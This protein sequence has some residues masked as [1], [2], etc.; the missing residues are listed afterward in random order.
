MMQD[1]HKYALALTLIPEIGLRRAK[2]LMDAFGSAQQVFCAKETELKDVKGLAVNVQKSLLAG[3]QAA[4]KRAEEEARFIDEKGIEVFY[5]RDTDYPYRLKDCVDAP[6]LLFGKGHMQVNPGKVLSIVGTRMPSDR[7]KELCRQLVLD[8]AAKVDDLT[9]VSGLAYGIDVAAHKAAIEAGIPTIIVPGHGLDR[10]YPSIHRNVAIQ[11]LAK[12]GLLTEYMSQTEPDRQ[13]FVARNR[14]IAGLADATVVVESKEKGGSLITADMASSYGRDVFAFPGRVSDQISVG[15]N[16]LIK[17]NQAALIESAEDVIAA[18]GWAEADRKQIAQQLN[19][20]DELSEAERILVDLLSAE[21]DG[22]QINLIAMELKR[23]YTE[24]MSTL[25][26]LEFRGVLK[27][28]PGGV[29][30]V[31]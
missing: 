24:V 30:K 11:S 7:G 27:S 17:R 26:Q 21:E 18:M 2:L 15:C 14:V 19:I 31:K 1:E 29:Y 10:I 13:N 28:L 3:R 5:Y 8:L 4:L 16:Q 6:V 25:M 9:I 22:M 12:G 23:P 20:F